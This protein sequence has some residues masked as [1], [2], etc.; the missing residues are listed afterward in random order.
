[1]IVFN[2]NHTDH[3][4]NN[5]KK[6]TS[7][8][9]HHK[10][11]YSTGIDRMDVKLNSVFHSG[12]LRSRII[13]QVLSNVSWKPYVLLRSLKMY[14][15]ASSINH[16]EKQGAVVAFHILRVIHQQQQITKKGHKKRSHQAEQPVGSVIH[17]RKPFE[18]Y[19]TIVVWP[20]VSFVELHI[21][22]ISD[23][24]GFLVFVSSKHDS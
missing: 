24:L 13:G 9:K 19:P 12:K 6:K 4:I 11:R 18:K 22:Q 14:P 7:T 3:N 17:F 10:K 5:L 20:R 2:F 1:M 23:T 16:L 15:E 21:S 8:T